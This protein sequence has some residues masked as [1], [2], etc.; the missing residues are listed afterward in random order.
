MALVAR[1]L[2]PLD[3]NRLSDAKLPYAE[4]QARAFNAEI[5]L[6]HVLSPERP[7]EESISPQ[8]ARARTFLEVTTARLRSDPSRDHRVTNRA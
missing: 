7:N 8:E 3:L 2:V 1:I 5:I 4:A 6:L